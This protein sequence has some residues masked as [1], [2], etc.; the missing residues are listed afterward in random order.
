MR[1]SHER[2]Y[3][4]STDKDVKTFFWGGKCVQRTLGVVRLANANKSIYSQHPLLF[5]RHMV[6]RCKRWST[7]GVFPCC[8]QTKHKKAAK[9]ACS[10]SSTKVALAV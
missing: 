4:T 10:R 1:R 3:R 2:M 7:S 9:A 5:M 8:L 6:E